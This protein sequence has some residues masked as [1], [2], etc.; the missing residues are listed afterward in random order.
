MI[1]EKL[2]NLNLELEKFSVVS[3]KLEYDKKNIQ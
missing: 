2:L 1:N 3:T